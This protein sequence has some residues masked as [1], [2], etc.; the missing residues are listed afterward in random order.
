MLEAGGFN[1]ADDDFI[2]S[3]R[4]SL[5]P[6]ESSQICGFQAELSMV[7]QHSTEIRGLKL[8]V[9]RTT[10]SPA[11]DHWSLRAPRELQLIVYSTNFIR[12]STKRSG[13]TDQID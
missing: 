2:R 6:A 12:E 4:S 1:G 5:F 9:Y 13:S 10:V 11:S 3:W 8:N 7:S